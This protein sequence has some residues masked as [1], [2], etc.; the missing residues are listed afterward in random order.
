MVL[1]VVRTHLTMSDFS[2]CWRIDIVASNSL[3]SVCITVVYK[4]VYV[5]HPH[6]NWQCCFGTSLAAILIAHLKLSPIELRQVLMTMATER[7]ESEH[8]MQLLLYAPDEVEVKQYEL[9]RQDPSKLSEPD[10]FVL[11][12]TLLHYYLTAGN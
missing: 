7:L 1:V 6:H 4:A 10:Q 2:D 11:Q 3:Y 12:V 9:Y 5:P 8:I